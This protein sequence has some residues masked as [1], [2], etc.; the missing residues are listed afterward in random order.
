MAAVFVQSAQSANGSATRTTTAAATLTVTAGHLLVVCASWDSGSTPTVSLADTLGSTWTALP[1]ANDSTDQQSNAMWW[2]IAGAGGSDTFT[3]TLS[4]S[5]D[6]FEMV[7]LEYSGVSDVD[8]TTMVA[9]QAATT[10]PAT[11]SVT[12]TAAGDLVLS[13]LGTTAGQS[14]TGH[15]SGSTQRCGKTVIYVADQVQASAGA[16]NPTWATASGKFNGF[17]ASFKA[18]SG[19]G[20]ST[21]AAA[22]ASAGVSGAAGAVSALLLAAGLVAG[23]TGATGNPA[24]VPRTFAAAGV[25]AGATTTA[26][27]AIAT[28]EASGSTPA[29]SGAA[30]AVTAFLP[31]SG[32]SPATSGAAGSVTAFLVASGTTAATSG[33]TGTADITGGAQTYPATGATVA[34]TTSAGTVT[35][36]V[37]SRTYDAAGAITGTSAASGT[38]QLTAG[39]SGVV[40][41]TTAI[42]GAAAIAS[43]TPARDIDVTASPVS[44]SWQ[45]MGTT[46]YP[47][48]TSAV[49]NNNGYAAGATT[50]DPWA[51]TPLINQWSTGPVWIQES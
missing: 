26:G 20:S 28:L 27:A 21:Y 24:R 30:G 48:T 49:N 44:T 7:A 17:T 22:G 2:T 45:V 13:H 31:T 40:N 1:V 36:I 10:T 37:G 18:T 39:A 16:I 5:S 19:G 34:V 33:A 3:V 41:A 35:L 50:V 11:G 15:P 23:V 51:A 6:Y 8:A 9:N 42:H 32:S 25:V 29:T 47:V 4:A 14:V 12:T 43:D 46:G 38:V